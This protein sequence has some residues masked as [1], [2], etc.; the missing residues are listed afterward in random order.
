MGRNFFDNPVLLVVLLLIIV[1]VFGANKLPTAA[2]SLGRSMRIF[3][4][5]VKA[6][7]DD[8]EDEP[9][10]N[11]AKRSPDAVEGRVIDPPENTAR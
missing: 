8:E 7:S 5:E 9:Q 4:S 1:V 2:R 10:T 3:K 11:T 6:L